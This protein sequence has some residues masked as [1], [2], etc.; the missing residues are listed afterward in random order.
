M[1]K[2]V[3][4]LFILLGCVP[5]IFAQKEIREQA[6][7]Y[8]NLA[9]NAEVEMTKHSGRDSV[10]YYRNVVSIVKN[11]LKSDEYNRMSNRRGKKEVK[12]E[13]QNKSLLHRYY[14]M[15]I[16]AGRF[17]AKHEATNAEGIEAFKLYLEK[18]ETS[19]LRQ[20]VDETGIAAYYLAYYALQN[21]NLEMANKYAD[22]ALK[23]DETA[24]AA[25]EVKAEYM[26]QTMKNAEDST[27]YLAVLSRL[28]RLEPTNK[29]YFSWIMRFY[30]KPT[31]RF[32]IEDFVDSRLEKESNSPI[33]WILKGE[34]AMNA[35]RWEEAIDAYKQADE[36]DPT[37]IPLIYN[38]GVSLNQQG[39]IMRDSVLARRKRGEIVSD[40]EFT[41][42]F[43]DARNYLERVR[44]KDPRR[45]KVDWVAPL[46]LVYQVLDDKI[47]ASELEPLVNKK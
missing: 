34:I 22:I 23:F 43:V 15:L 17:F 7:N 24:R 27:K 4:I 10:R 8:N 31:P 14:P 29:K 13:E 39:T 30:E 45:N 47:K 3:L 6:E 36:L 25:A 26:Q 41:K 42:Y 18:K 40:L 12:L 21:R 16:D 20:E 11:A 9:R 46:Y 33:P 32:N 5:S 28:Y 37:N 1:K 19:L 44:A 38:I 2:V 35:G